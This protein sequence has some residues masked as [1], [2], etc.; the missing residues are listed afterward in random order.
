MGSA[1]RLTL[2]KFIKCTRYKWNLV[3][4]T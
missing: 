4:T 1:L 2:T 3:V